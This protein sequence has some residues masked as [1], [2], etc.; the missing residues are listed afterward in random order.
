[1]NIDNFRATRTRVASLEAVGIECYGVDG[2]D[3]MPNVVDKAGYVYHGSLYIEIEDDG[4]LTLSIEG[5]SWHGPEA[6]MLAG[7]EQRLF[8]YGIEACVFD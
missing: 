8:D 6:D 7:F 2:P 1:M 5:D 4:T 3:G